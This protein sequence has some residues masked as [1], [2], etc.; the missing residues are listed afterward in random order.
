MIAVNARVGVATADFF[1]TFMLTGTAGFESADVKSM[2]DWKSRMA[3]IGPS[4][5]IPIFEG[6]RLKANLEATKA[7]YRQVVAAYVGQVLVAYGDVEDALTDLHSLTDQTEDLRRAL[8]AAGGE[9]P[10][11]PAPYPPRG[12]EYPPR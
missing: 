9:T 6:G 3:S 4:V 10:P 5:S 2:F 8:G 7:Q 1:P 11:A 12:V